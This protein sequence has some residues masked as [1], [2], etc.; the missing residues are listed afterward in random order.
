M[1]PHEALDFRNRSEAAQRALDDLAEG[2]FGRWQ[3]PKPGAQGG[4]PK[5]V[6][7]LHKRV[8]ETE[9]PAGDTGIGGFGDRDTEEAPSAGAPTSARTKFEV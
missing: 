2:G 7:V 9:N 6:F 5:A 4:R 1:L 8:T 3:W